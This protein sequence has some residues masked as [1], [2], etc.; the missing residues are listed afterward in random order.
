MFHVAK[1]C[2]LARMGRTVGVLAAVVC[3]GALPGS[4]RAQQFT[5]VTRTAGIDFS[6]RWEGEYSSDYHERDLMPGAAAADYDG[7][8]WTDLFI[9]NGYMHANVLYHNEG[10]TFV[11]VTP[12]SIE[13][14]EEESA[15]GL[16]FDYDGDGDLDLA[17]NVNGAP[18]EPRPTLLQPR[19]FRNDTPAGQGG[20][21]VFTD[22][23]V[24]AGIPSVPYAGAFVRYTNAAS[25]AAGDLD[26]DGD[27]ELYLCYWRN[28]D[29]LL[30]N[31]GDGTFTDVADEAGVG[32]AADDT[33]QAMIHD[34]NNDGRLDLF[35]AIDYSANRLYINQGNVAGVPT[36]TDVAKQVG[37]A[38]AEEEPF[39]EMG[40]SLGDFDNDGDL[41]LY[42]SNVETPYG[43]ADLYNW[44]EL[45]RN[46]T[47][48]TSVA[49]TEVARDCS[50][51][52]GGWGWGVAFVDF[53]NDGW[54]DIA[55]VNGRGY[56]YSPNY[57]NDPTHM[58]R[59]TLG[60]PVVG[61]PIYE[62][63]S[64]LVGFHD[65]RA[66]RACL[67]FDYDRDGDLD[68]F[69]TNFYKP[70]ASGSGDPVLLRNE[71]RSDGGLDG[72]KYNWLLVDPIDPSGMNRRSISAIVYVTAGGVEQMK[73]ITAGTSFLGQEPDEALFGI[74]SAE[75][76]DEIRVVWP[77]GEEK[78]ACAQPANSRFVVTKGPPVAHRVT[79]DGPA[80][81]DASS[82]APFS[83]TVEYDAP[84]QG[85]CSA[86]VTQSATWSVSPAA[87]VAIEAGMLT[88]A[89]LAS[90]VTV[91]VTASVNGVTATHEVTVL[92]EFEDVTAPVVALVAP[93]ALGAYVTSASSVTLG[94]T[95]SDDVGVTSV[96]WEVEGVSGTCDGDASWS[97]DE[98]PLHDG[99][100]EI[101]I[102][103]GD[104]AGNTEVVLVA[105]ARLDDLTDAVEVSAQELDFGT[106]ADELPLTITN[107]SGVELYYVLEAGAEWIDAEPALVTTLAAGTS[108]QHTVTIHRTSLEPGESYASDLVVSIEN[109]SGDAATIPVLADE[110][111]GA[112][113]QLVVVITSPVSVASLTTANDSIVLGGSVTGGV[114]PFEVT[115]SNDRGGSG[116]ANGGASW[117]TGSVALS[118][119][120]N[121]LTVTATD[122]LGEAATAELHVTVS[123][124]VD[125]MDKPP[126]SPTPSGGCGTAMIGLIGS[127]AALVTIRARRGR[128]PRHYSSSHGRANRRRAGRAVMNPRDFA[129]CRGWLRITG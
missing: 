69:L 35:L 65:R 30:L 98:I 40:A 47:V 21:P 87:G 90:A 3:A 44:N 27:L 86:D 49:F 67:A 77:D 25:M 36:F 38:F 70:E 18:T 103:A 62:E 42:I 128:L 112:T 48:G 41:D 109:G 71:E 127:F 92:P 75:Q 8:G 117:S 9:T 72:D 91:Q 16:F 123:T 124:G 82:P 12:A 63:V 110:L 68:M 116:V 73:I 108:Q 66:T 120:L 32:D 96:G 89:E 37:I 2:A 102:T 105:V 118:E 46:D 14:M 129:A 106:S 119:G 81:V 122:A 85:V 121:V 101:S 22:V 64:D 24:E 45:F 19:L 115:W 15:A 104:A 76:V 23:T 56:G 74:G 97:C 39:N 94:G 31:N 114:E 17:I 100:Q 20:S 111:D 78:E 99:V 10:G 57:L 125:P 54:Q 50:V 80:I 28:K 107:T 53:D 4:A 95:A 5:D 52:H 59:N 33:W 11:D 34:F 79:I 7:D 113:G 84:V 126:S 1:V 51:D 93:T 88:V 60:D 6:H 58:F 13:M 83:A 55:A 29:A 61:D 26:G 43:A